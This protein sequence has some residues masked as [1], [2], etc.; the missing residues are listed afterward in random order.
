[1]KHWPP[2]VSVAYILVT[3]MTRGQRSFV[4]SETRFRGL[5]LNAPV[6]M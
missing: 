6:A 4:E 1:M 3:D 2:Q 5:F